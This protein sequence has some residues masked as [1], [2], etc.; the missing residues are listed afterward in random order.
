MDYSRTINRF[1]ELDAYSLPRIDLKV[2]KLAQCKIFHTLDLKSAYHHVPFALEDRIYTAFEAD[3][4]LYQFCRL[5][6]AVKTGV[7]AF[8]K[9]I[10]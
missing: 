3:G 2:D 4:K 6:F 7:S 9:N 10:D 5:P 1:T 8:Q